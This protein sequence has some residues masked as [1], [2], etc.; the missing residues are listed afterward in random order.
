MRVLKK[1]VGSLLDQLTFEKTLIMKHPLTKYGSIKIVIEIDLIEVVAQV[2]ME[3][4]VGAIA[5]VE[6]VI[7][8]AIVRIIIIT[9]EIIQNIHIDHQVDQIIITIIEIETIVDQ[10]EIEVDQIGVITGQIG[11]IIIHLHLV[12]PDRVIPDIPDFFKNDSAQ[13]PI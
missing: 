11:I 10:T 7:S 6:V 1:R 13:A 9:I 8:V 5:K 12:N 2:E 4:L 3:A